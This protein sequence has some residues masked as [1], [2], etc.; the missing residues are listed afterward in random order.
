MG[1]LILR[2]PADSRY[3]VL[4]HRERSRGRDGLALSFASGGDTFALD[5]FVDAD[6][7]DFAGGPIQ[8]TP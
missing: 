2:L 4:A 1:L 3:S 8:I 6:C 5:R 7:S